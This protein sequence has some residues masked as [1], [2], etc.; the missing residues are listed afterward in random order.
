MTKTLFSLTLLFAFAGAVP[1]DD[2]A[3]DLK[4]LVGTWEEVSHSEDGKAKSADE[5][6]GVTVVIDEKGNWQALKDG[7]VIVKG[8][9]KKLDPSKKP[10]EADWI[11][12][13]F[14]MPV[15]GIYEVKDD[16]WKHCFAVAKRPTEFASKEGSGVTYIVLK[17]VKK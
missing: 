2:A 14:D 17:R 4:K 5:I 9:V 6:K 12:E 11:V 8:S 7:T 13:G 1:A 15:L 16:T 3:N 10:R